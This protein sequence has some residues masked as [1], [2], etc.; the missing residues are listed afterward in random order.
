MQVHGWTG[1]GPIHSIIPCVS[2]LEYSWGRKK[3][4]KGISKDVLSYYDISH[5]LIVLKSTIVFGIE[6]HVP[7]FLVAEEER[8][9][10]DTCF[11][12]F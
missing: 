5:N 9:G 10:Q 1:C 4:R 7:P 11:M 8:E 6:K 12:L 3:K 2:T